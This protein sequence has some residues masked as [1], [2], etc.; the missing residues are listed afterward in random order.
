MKT[1]TILWVSIC[2]CLL[3]GAVVASAADDPS[4]SSLV[5]KTKGATKLEEGKSGATA[6]STNAIAVPPMAAPRPVSAVY[7]TRLKENKPQ[8]IQNKK[9]GGPIYAAFTAKDAYQWI[10]PFAPSRYGGGEENMPKDPSTG[11]PA[12]VTL[13]VVHRWGAE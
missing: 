11:R 3:G 10:N 8:P 12:G 7:I 2:C 6:A 13:F 9:Y 1:K 5:I 4:A